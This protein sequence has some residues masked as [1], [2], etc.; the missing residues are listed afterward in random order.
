MQQH[1]KLLMFP[2]INL[3][4]LLVIGIFFFMPL[5]VDINVFSLD[6]DIPAFQ[7]RMEQSRAERLA[8]AEAR[9]ATGIAGLRQA[10]EEDEPM[11]FPFL[12]MAVVYL[13][14]MFLTTFFN[15][16]FYNEILQAF[17]GNTVSISR[18]LSFAMTRLRAIVLW[19]L[20]A[21]IVGIIIRKI[22]E[23]VGFVGR[24]ITGLIGFTW[25]VASVF[26][27]PVIVREPQQINPITT[28][29][30]SAALIKRTWGEGLAGMVGMSAIIILFIIALVALSVVVM[31]AIPLSILYLSIFIFLTIFIL[32]YLSM[33]MRDI[34]LCGLYVYATEGVVPGEFD[35]AMMEQ[36]WRVKKRK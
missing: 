26:A 36:A 13:I 15:V 17:N 24:W 2:M 6:E 27:I 29:K 22:E 8:E 28:L 25:S 3:L 33:M 7:E 32:G 20:L 31:I 14:T 23:N 34:F 16:A 35:E 9:R 5:L 1:P 19:S 18:G 10:I 30:D 12:P 21:G 11:S 4:S